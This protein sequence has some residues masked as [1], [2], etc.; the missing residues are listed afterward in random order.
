M[1]LDLLTV[2]LILRSHHG[3]LGRPGKRGGSTPF[4]D[5]TKT[6]EETGVYKKN[7][8]KYALVEKIGQKYRVTK[9]KRSSL[10]PIFRKE[11]NLHNKKGKAMREGEDFINA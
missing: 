1:I 11:F 6:L 10:G 9:A 3:H 7:G 2:T 4:V 8:Q 5:W